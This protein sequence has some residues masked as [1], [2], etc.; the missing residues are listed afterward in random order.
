[1]ATNIYLANVILILTAAALVYAAVT[2]LSQYKVRNDLI[3]VLAG[4][5]VVHAV[6][7]GR[8]VFIHW[9]LGFAVLM[10]ACMLYFYSQGLIGG[11]DVKLSTVAFLWAGIHCAL[12]FAI[13]LLVFASLHSAAA[14]LGWAASRQTENDPRKRIPFAPSVAC[15]LIGIFLLGCLQPNG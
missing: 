9:N 12:A 15:A 8:W 11:G 4:L 10:F 7:S 1:M 3:L 2:D 5:F 13:L 14:K 6:L